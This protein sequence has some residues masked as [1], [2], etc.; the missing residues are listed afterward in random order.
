MNEYELL[1][2]F[3]SPILNEIKDIDSILETVGAEFDSLNVSIE[4]LGKQLFPQ[5]CTW[6]ID[7]WEEFLNL[8]NK[9]KPLEL[10]RALVIAKL[11]GSNALNKKR[12][13]DIIRNYTK[14]STADVLYHYGK[15]TFAIKS[16]IDYNTIGLNELIEEIKPVH[17]AYFFI[18]TVLIL[19][20]K[21][22]F[23]VRNVNRVF[24]KTNN[25]QVI[26]STKIRCSISNLNNFTAR[27]VKEKKLWYLDGTYNLDGTKLLNA[28][29]TKEEL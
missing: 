28:E 13:R 17:L 5:S 9:D 26:K 12:F 21:E 1:K 19:K 18:F 7:Y 27:V 2:S 8:N 10:R 25:K 4:D 11:S 29:R 16:N 15:Y 3:L 14:D 24:I 6:G 23:K 20:N 22:R